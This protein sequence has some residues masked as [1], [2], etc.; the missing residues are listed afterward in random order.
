MHTY[1][2]TAACVQGLPVFTG[3]QHVHKMR[4]FMVCGIALGCLLMGTPCLANAGEVQPRARREQRP[5]SSTGRARSTAQNRPETTTQNTTITSMSMMEEAMS[6]PPPLPTSEPVQ[7]VPAPPPSV[8]AGSSRFPEGSRPAAQGPPTP[9]APGPSP[10]PPPLAATPDPAP[11][12]AALSPPAETPPP[13]PNG[14]PEGA[15]LFM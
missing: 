6:S 8:R 15:H 11:A 12:P 7:A 13:A 14:L 9:A 3:T 2:H 10:A 5:P 4:A 1:V